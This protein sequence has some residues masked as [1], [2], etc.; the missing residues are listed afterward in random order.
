V[1]CDADTALPLTAVSTPGGPARAGEGGEDDSRCCVCL[2]VCACVRACVRVR[3]GRP[4]PTDGDRSAS[5]MR[6]S[7][8]SVSFCPWRRS[9]S[10]MSR[11]TYSMSASKSSS[12]SCASS[13]NLALSF[14]ASS[15]RARHCAASSR[16]LL[17]ATPGRLRT[18][19][20]EPSLLFA[21]GAVSAWLRVPRRRA[22]ACSTMAS[23][24]IRSSDALDG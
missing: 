24:L 15:Y 22:P 21:R 13:A 17:S 8:R 4:R 12:F 16:R 7:R 1:G 2:W 23:A 3:V 18:R 14:S 20:L 10:L 19:S 9:F 6:S 11:S 5:G